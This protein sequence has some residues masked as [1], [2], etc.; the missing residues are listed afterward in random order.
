[1]AVSSQGLLD[2]LEFDIELPGDLAIDFVDVTLGDT[3]LL[4]ALIG[5]RHDQ[6]K[7]GYSMSILNPPGI[8]RL[9]LVTGFRK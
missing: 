6:M 2:N 4:N 1:M 3:A 9:F 5:I 7:R 8:L